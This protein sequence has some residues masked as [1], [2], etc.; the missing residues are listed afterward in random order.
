MRTLYLL[1]HSLTEANERR[2]Y[3]GST[4]LPLSPKG[5]ALALEARE[6]L[7]LP[8]IDTGITSG[9]RR[10][11]ETLALLTGS[12]PDAIIPSLKEM[13]FGRFES[14]GYE[15]LK[16]D[17]DYR[18]WIGDASGE[19]PCPG[20]E[21]NNAFRRRV[22]MGRAALLDL[23]WTTAILVSHGGVI[24]DLMREWFPAEDRGFYEWQP[25]PCAGWRV[26][27]GRRTPVCFSSLLEAL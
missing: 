2:L 15:E 12:G 6:R 25:A 27:F 24:V 19:T 17:P 14:K 21:S 4:D 8:A 5:R 11:N 7:R 9:L 26:D 20:G 22:S 16:D 1:R 23:N 3:C 10:A 18:R 13:D